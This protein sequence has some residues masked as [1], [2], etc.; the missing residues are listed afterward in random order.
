MLLSIY[1]LQKIMSLY[2]STYKLDTV[3]SAIEI[4]VIVQQLP[5]SLFTHFTPNFLVHCV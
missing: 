2:I 5:P 1:F 4:V 3:Y